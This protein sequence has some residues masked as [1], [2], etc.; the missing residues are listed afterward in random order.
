MADN[1]INLTSSHLSLEDKKEKMQSEYTEDFYNYHQE[2]ARQSAKEIVPLVLGM[3]PCKNV[4]D[5]G[6]G[7]GTW[8]KVF[9]EYGVEEILGVDGDYVTPDTLIIPK[10]KFIPFNLQTPLQLNQQFDLVVSLEVAEHLPIECAEI[11]IDT[12]T[13]LGKVILF[14]AA[15]PYQGGINHINEQWP[16]YWEKLFENKDYLVI[17]YIRKKI[18]DN[19]NIAYYYKQNILIFAQRNYLEN[20]PTLAQKTADAWK[21]EGASCISVVHPGLYIDTQKEL[22]SIKRELAR[23]TKPEE[24]SLRKTL[25]L[26]PKVIIQTLKRRINLLSKSCIR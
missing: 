15:I 1:L 21:S 13:S 10:E 19:D 23:W 17:D 24:M 12:L 9:Q 22:L 14:S 11:F 8:L 18:W 16:D 6:C 25:E 2:E 20:Y 5:V 7:K 3:I 4:V 26:L